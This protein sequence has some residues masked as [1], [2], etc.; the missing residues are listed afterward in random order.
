MSDKMHILDIFVTVL[1]V[2]AIALLGSVAATI[3]VEIWGCDFGFFDS[4]LCDN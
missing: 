4:P 1:G 2:I 3:L